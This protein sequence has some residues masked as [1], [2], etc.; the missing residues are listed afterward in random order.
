MSLL[1]H[2]VTVGDSL[3]GGGN[4]PAFT[5]AHTVDLP[6]GK[7]GKSWVSRLMPSLGRVVGLSWVMIYAPRV[8][9]DLGRIVGGGSGGLFIIQMQC[10]SFYLIEYS[11]KYRQ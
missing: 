5:H 11:I 7:N 8:E 9:M 6:M 10:L 2:T 1:R 3:M 4:L